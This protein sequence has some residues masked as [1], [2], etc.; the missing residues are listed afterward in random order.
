MIQLSGSKWSPKQLL[1]PLLV[2]IGQHCTAQQSK[3]GHKAA[4]HSSFA[5]TWQTK[6]SGLQ[7]A[8]R[9]RCWSPLGRKK[10]TWRKAHAAPPTWK[11]QRSQVQ[12]DDFHVFV[13]PYDQISWNKSQAE[14]VSVNIR[15]HFCRSHTSALYGLL[16][17]IWPKKPFWFGTFSWVKVTGRQ[18]LFFLCAELVNCIYY[19]MTNLK[20]KY[21]HKRLMML[22]K[23]WNLTKDEG[24]PSLS[25]PEIK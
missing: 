20:T 4:K 1:C 2:A 25:A 10:G 6:G 19:V 16:M 22:W 14:T 23:A 9:Q 12:T 24:C 18:F 7:R 11:A 21:M 3:A 15:R 8:H 5:S 13:G 17:A